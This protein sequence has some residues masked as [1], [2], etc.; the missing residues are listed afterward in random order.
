MLIGMAA[1]LLVGRIPAAAE[2]GRS[3]E[4]QSAVSVPKRSV[5]IDR[6]RIGRPAT[7]RLPAGRP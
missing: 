2:A 4:L 3:Q 7:C 6:V 1:G 5:V